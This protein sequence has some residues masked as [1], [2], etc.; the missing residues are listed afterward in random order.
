[1]P[2]TKL[3]AQ[4]QQT[5]SF[6]VNACHFYGSFKTENEPLCDGFEIK[7]TTN[8]INIGEDVDLR[9]I[10]RQLIDNKTRYVVEDP[11]SQ[12]IGAFHG[13]TPRGND[14]LQVVFKSNKSDKI[15]S[16]LTFQYWDYV[17]SYDFWRAERKKK[18]LTN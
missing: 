12:I 3:F 7:I 8:Y 10:S 2:M 14:Y 5:K 4:A 1:M 15:E 9:I 11:K 16:G 18:N 13:K 17:S 6:Y